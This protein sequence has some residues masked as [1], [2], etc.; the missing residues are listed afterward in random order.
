MECTR[1][2]FVMQC[3][4]CRC[5]MSS[6]LIIIEHFFYLDFRKDGIVEYDLKNKKAHIEY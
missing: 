6:V 2:Q 5:P 4:C 3:C 1:Q